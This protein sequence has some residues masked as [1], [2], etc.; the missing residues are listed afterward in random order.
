[1][2][3]HRMHSLRLYCEERQ[4]PFQLRAKMEAYF[5]FQQHHSTSVSDQVV[6]VRSTRLDIVAIKLCISDACWQ[7]P[8]INNSKLSIVQILPTSLQARIASQQ[9]KHTLSRNS[10]LLNNCTDQFL[11]RF[12]TALTEI[13]L[14]PGILLLTLAWAV[15]S[16]HGSRRIGDYYCGQ[17][18]ADGNRMMCTSLLTFA[19]SPASES[20]TSLH[21]RVHKLMFLPQPHPA[22]T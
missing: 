22:T 12:M 18:R 8:H 20:A 16:C 9:C 7:A 21:Y 11:D 1:M 19:Y 5:V 13:S 2:N 14:M 10:N 3:R 15:K 4:L 17:T 6:K